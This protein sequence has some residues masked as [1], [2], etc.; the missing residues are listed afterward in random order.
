MTITTAITW[1][2]VEGVNN[3]RDLVG[4]PAKDGRKIAA[5]R[6]LRSDN[7][8]RLT[9]ASIETLVHQHDLTDVIDLRTR[10]E[11]SRIGAGPL[12]DDPRVQV[13]TG[14]LYP[15]DDP[16]AVIP[17]WRETMSAITPTTRNEAMAAHYLE[18]LEARPDTVL[19]G[20][21]VLGSARGATD[22]HCAAGKDRTGTLMAVVLTALGVPREAIVT[23]Y[24]ATNQRLDRIMASLGEAA[25]AGS[26]T[27]GAYSGP[28]QTTPAEIMTNLLDL[29]EQ[30]HGGVANYLDRIGWQGE[31]Q[32]RLESHLLTA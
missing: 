6:L 23:D 12:R 17:P 1:I 26:A 7:L 3:M 21:R 32:A 8:D 15:E 18:Y 16:R 20:L 4:T 14:S 2:D 27:Q 31:D 19:A 25:A 9:P 30:R 24:E 28:E 13:T 5:N 10:Y 22:I 29:V 11:L